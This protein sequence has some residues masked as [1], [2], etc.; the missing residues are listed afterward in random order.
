MNQIKKYLDN[1]GVAWHKF[2]RLGNQERIVITLEKDN[3]WVNG[4]GE[5]MK[6]DRTITIHQN[7]WKK[8][9]AYIETGYNMGQTLAVSGKQSDIITNINKVLADWHLV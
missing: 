6:W 3:V 5:E 2:I 4:Y 8:Y 7:S 1:N 9:V